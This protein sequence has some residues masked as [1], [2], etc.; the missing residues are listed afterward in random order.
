MAIA[1]LVHAVVLTVLGAWIRSAASTEADISHSPLRADGCPRQIGPGRSV[2]GSFAPMGQSISTRRLEL[3]PLP[4]AAGAALQNDRE[5]AVQEIGVQLAPDWPQPALL[6]ILHRQVT[7]TPEEVVWGIWMI[8][9]RSDETVVGDIGFHGPPSDAGVVEVGYCVVP[10]RRCR[11]Y[12]TEAARALVD[13]ARRQREVKSIVAGCDPD[14]RAS[15]RT[16]ERAGFRPTGSSG[17]ELRWK[18]AD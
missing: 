13:W 18:L 3:R 7:M 11:G 8:I 16:L 14:N 4:A 1:G 17:G 5:R 6:N 10:G 15:V 12:A 9:D 2:G